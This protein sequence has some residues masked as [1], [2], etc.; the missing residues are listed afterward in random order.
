VLI[1]RLGGYLNAAFW[2]EGLRSFADGHVGV[3]PG[4]RAEYYSLSDEWVVDPRLVVS[5]H[6]RPWLTVRESAGVFHQPPL[7][8]DYL[9]GNTDLRS[10]R[11]VQSAIGVDARLP[12]GI[13][14]S[15]TGYYSVLYDLPI[16]DPLAEDATYAS[17]NPY[18]G[19][20]IASSREYIGRQFG[21]FSVLENTGEGRNCGAEIL[22]R[23]AGPRWFGWISYT[24]SRSERREPRW[25]WT[26]YVLD[27]PH[28]LSALAATRLG[29]WRLGARV[30]YATGTPITPVVGS[31]YIRNEG[32]YEP[33]FQ[34]PPFGER[35]P[36]AFQIDLRVD[37]IWRRAWGTVALYLD[38]QNLTN[39]TN[40]EGIMY[41]DDYSEFE[42]THGL[43]FFPSFGLEIEQAVQPAA[44][45]G[46]LIG[47]TPAK[48]PGDQS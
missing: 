46:A 34:L 27:Q 24:A 3:K 4:V 15:L 22:L 10:S 43:P 36:D 18:I 6:P 16:N 13:S 26:P 45:K 25:D 32:V 38:V 23:R 7:L 28:V 40:I 31:T 2:A 11:S 41:N 30:R 33:I 42:N 1:R 12:L 44:R 47:A 5:Q 29:R 48:S 21:A 9:W 8:A 39:H 37:R 19:G 17:V 20:A 14:A 35:L